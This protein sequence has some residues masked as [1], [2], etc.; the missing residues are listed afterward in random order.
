M[1]VLA[2]SD[3]QREKEKL[4]SLETKNYFLLTIAISV[5]IFLMILSLF[6]FRLRS[7]HLKLVEKN[8]EIA[9]V[10]RTLEKKEKKG[11]SPNNSITKTISSK[12]IELFENFENYMKNEKAYLKNDISINYISHQLNTNRT[13]L[14]NAINACLKKSFIAYI[15]ELR[16]KEAVNR[17]TLGQYKEMTIEGIAIEVGF[18]NR[19]SFNTAFKK[20]TGVLPSYFL[21]EISK[22]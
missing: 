19:V 5:F 20:Y 7:A 12:Q 16:I 15:N 22:R 21:S 18:N 13:Y 4:S 11:I 10:N 8:I 1:Q 3:Y 9:S 2:E 17:I 14:S 6:Y